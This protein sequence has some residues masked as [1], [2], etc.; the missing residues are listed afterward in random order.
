MKMCTP[1]DNL[2]ERVTCSALF[3]IIPRYPVS[4]GA[5]EPVPHAGTAAAVSS[6]CIDFIGDTVI[7]FSM[8]KPVNMKR[9]K[10]CC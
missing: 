8:T 10:L 4:A 1:Q 7:C 3:R 2:P 9:S 5:P 6:F